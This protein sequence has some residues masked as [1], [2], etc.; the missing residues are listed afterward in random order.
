MVG[1]LHGCPMLKLDFCSN[2]WPS[3]YIILVICSFVFLNFKTRIV[4]NYLHS[5]HLLLLVGLLLKVAL[6]KLFFMLFVYYKDSCSTY[7]TQR[8]SR[9]LGR[10]AQIMQVGY[11]WLCHS[12]SQHYYCA[13][14]L[15]MDVW[16]VA[17]PTNLDF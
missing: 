12:G 8:C 4:S 13:P 5:R 11:F 10:A 7:S 14:N 16:L 6:Y 1:A 2:L 15:C 9:P 3:V 17:R